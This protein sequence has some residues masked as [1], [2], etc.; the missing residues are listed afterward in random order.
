MTVYIG[1]MSG[2][3]NNSFKKSNLCLSTLPGGRKLGFRISI[4]TGTKSK[5]PTH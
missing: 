5:V 4:A 2:W 3:E 1:G